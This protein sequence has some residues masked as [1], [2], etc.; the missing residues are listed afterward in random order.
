MRGNPE[1]PEKYPGFF[2]LVADFDVL[3]DDPLLVIM[4]GLG[5]LPGKVIEIRF[6][7]ELPPVGHVD[8]APLAVLDKDEIGEVVDHRPEQVPL[9][10]EFDLGLLFGR[11]IPEDANG[12]ETRSG[13]DASSSGALMT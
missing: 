11:D 6:A 13:V 5:H 4:E 1:S 7:D 10:R 12:S 8:V 2:L 3:L 9:L